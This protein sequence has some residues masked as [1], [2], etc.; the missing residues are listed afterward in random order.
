VQKA[1]DLGTWYLGPENR[2]G[3]FSQDLIKKG[4]KSSR[5]GYYLLV[6]IL[7]VLEDLQSRN[8]AVG[9]AQRG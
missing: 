5:K 4:G 9:S 7:R 1:E 3:L 8:W 2:G 6:I